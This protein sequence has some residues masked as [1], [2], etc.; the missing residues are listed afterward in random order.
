M[1]FLLDASAALAMLAQRLSCLKF[2]SA[3]AATW[4]TIL[5]YADLWL[6][7][8]RISNRVLFLLSMNRNAAITHALKS[9][10]IISQK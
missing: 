4:S 9:K 5:D 6:L 10:Q 7:H 2:L 1:L 8:K 3:L